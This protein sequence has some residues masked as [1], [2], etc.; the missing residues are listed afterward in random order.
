MKD[1]VLD[2]S[3]ALTWCFS[4]Q[5]CR[6]GDTILQ[7]LVEEV[8]IVPALWWLEIANVTALAERRGGLSKAQR[9]RFFELLDSLRITTDP[10][11][12]PRTLGA[13][14]DLALAHQ[15]TVYDAT[16]LEVAQRTRTPLATLDEPL[17]RAA[18]AAGI[19][20][21]SVDA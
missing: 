20:L 11:D 17:R 21:A 6:Y 4:D 16:F 3:V 14:L 7:R 18:T 5:R 8:A 10:V 9:S 12:A 19:P 15:L 2:S 1:V 13:V